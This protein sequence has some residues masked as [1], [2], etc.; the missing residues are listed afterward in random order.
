MNNSDKSDLS[1]E[2]KSFRKL[3]WPGQYREAKLT[4][5]FVEWFPIPSL[6]GCHDQ[7]ASP[8]KN[9]SHKTEACVCSPSDRATKRVAHVD[10]SNVFVLN[11]QR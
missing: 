10:G 8:Q 3:H 7:A 11:T 9:G 6:I 5:A 1:R 4:S 2:T